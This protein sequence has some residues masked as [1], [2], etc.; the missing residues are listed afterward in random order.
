M[1]NVLCCFQENGVNLG[2]SHK[3]LNLNLQFLFCK[4]NI[5]TTL[6]HPSVVCVN[7]LGLTLCVGVNVNV[8]H[9]MCK[10]EN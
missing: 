7:T 8:K 2:P 1:V 10:V 6:M 5:F 9:E 4:P 3:N